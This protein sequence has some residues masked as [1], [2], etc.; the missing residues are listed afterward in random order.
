MKKY[1]LTKRKKKKVAFR[2]PGKFILR[3][4]QQIAK[5]KIKKR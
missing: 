2:T 3:K 1:S 4:C 5:L